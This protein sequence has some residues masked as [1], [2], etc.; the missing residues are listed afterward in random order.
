MDPS[1]KRA[2][3]LGVRAPGESEAAKGSE[4]ARR[5]RASLPWAQNSASMGPLLNR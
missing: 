5:L 3:I 2:E 4:R 1:S